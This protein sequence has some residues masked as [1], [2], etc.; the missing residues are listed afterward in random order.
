MDTITDNERRLLD[1]AGIKLKP[2]YET[3]IE[4]LSATKITTELYVLKDTFKTFGPDD[5]PTIDVTLSACIEFGNDF[6]SVRFQ[7][8]VILDLGDQTE[9][10]M[11]KAHDIKRMVRK[12]LF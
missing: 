2:P 8:N 11:R 4:W 10:F 9:S 1:L 5:R 6:P 12:D 3:G 7:E